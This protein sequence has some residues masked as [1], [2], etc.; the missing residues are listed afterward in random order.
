MSA[1]VASVTSGIFASARESDETLSIVLDVFSHK[2]A[3][4][5]ASHAIMTS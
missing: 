4:Q 1:I 3:S 2:R 5:L